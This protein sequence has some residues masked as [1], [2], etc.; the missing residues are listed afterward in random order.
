MLFS[1]DVDYKVQTPNSPNDGSVNRIAAKLKNWAV[2]LFF[3]YC[4]LK[5]VTYTII[6]FTNPDTKANII[7]Q[8]VY[9]ILHEID[10][11]LHINKSS[12]TDTEVNTSSNPTSSS[13][14]ESSTL[15]S[16]EGSSTPVLT[17]VDR[18][19]KDNYSYQ[20]VV[21]NGDNLN[22]IAKQHEMT[23]EEI[24]S[25]NTRIKVKNDIKRGQK[26]KVIAWKIHEVQT[27][28]F[29]TAI[30][31]KYEVSYE[32]IMVA[33]KLESTKILPGEVLIIPYR[34][35]NFRPYVQG[36][37]RVK[38]RLIKRLLYRNTKR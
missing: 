31:N 18:G 11:V 20:Y 28:E 36:D 13:N 14:Q 16:S 19:L 5:L 17:I 9:D 12:N 23:I 10:T 32:R 15:L 2:I 30:A 4:T 38:G 26:I 21:R 29:L 1:N 8:S 24:L 6:R 35:D 27:G 22:H 33:N 25:N 34:D 37:I 7:A 3:S